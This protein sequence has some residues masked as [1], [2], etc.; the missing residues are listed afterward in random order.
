VIEPAL[1]DVLRAHPEVKAAWLFG[2][3]AGGT[4]RPESDVDIGVLVGRKPRTLA[5]LG[6]ALADELQHA[7]GRPIDLVV[8]DGA[9]VDL[10]MRVLRQGRLLVEHDRAA[11]VAFEVRT[12]FTWWDFAPI[13]EV[14]RGMPRGSLT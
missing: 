7:A 14:T 13:L 9:P 2:S 5:E 3:H 6:G 4:A 11:R 10:A 8:L 1:L 12:R